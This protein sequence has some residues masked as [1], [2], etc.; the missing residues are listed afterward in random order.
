MDRKSKFQVEQNNHYKEVLVQ[1]NFHEA[2]SQNNIIQIN[3]PK[4][5]F[6]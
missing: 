4:P 3:K 1:L 2:F 6:H 5:Y